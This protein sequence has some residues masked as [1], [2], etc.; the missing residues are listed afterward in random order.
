MIVVG[1]ALLIV[2]RNVIGSMPPNYQNDDD[3]SFIQL[4]QGMAKLL[5]IAGILFLL[6]G[7]GCE[8]FALHM[9]S[10]AAR[11]GVSSSDNIISDGDITT[12][13][14][15][16]VEGDTT[17]EDD[18]TIEEDAPTKD[19]TTIEE[20]TPTKDDITSED[21]TEQPDS[22]TTES[23]P[24]TENVPAVV[25]QPKITLSVKGKSAII[26][27]MDN[28]AILY[29]K[30]AYTKRANASTVKLL[31][32]AVA[33]EHMPLSKRI[34]ITSYAAKTEPQK[35]YMRRG[36]R[37]YLKDLL[38]SMLMRSDNDCAVAV[39]EGT[40]GS[41]KKFMRLANQKAQEIGCS[42]TYF[43]TPNG[44]DT[45]GKQYTTAYD[46]ALITK[47][48]YSNDTVQKILKKKTYRFKSKQGRRHTVRNINILLDSKKYYCVG[49]TGYTSRAGFCFAGVYT[50]QGHSYVLITLGCKTSVKRWNDVK[51]MIRACQS[52]Q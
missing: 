25:S 23:N 44:L 7:V 22:A 34:K 43:S 39:A 33:V 3:G 51:K 6:A 49:K 41:V 15:T 24:A 35:L 29:E 32:A 52:I 28:G 12:K 10:N 1:I 17:T 14:D 30:K 8:I 46:L 18:T 36:D 4:L 42:N 9:T 2:A 27:D 45:N 38:Y 31:T 11:A 47:Y 16:E 50:Y 26:M 19:D 40:A 5:S 20:D 21:N 13:D 37:Y 48:A